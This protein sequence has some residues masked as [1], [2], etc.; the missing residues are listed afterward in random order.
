MD[1]LVHDV[2]YKNYL[3][4]FSSQMKTIALRRVEIAYEQCECDAIFFLSCTPYG[5]SCEK[6][7]HRVAIRDQKHLQAIVINYVRNITNC[8]KYFLQTAMHNLT[9]LS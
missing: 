1:G 4:S 6:K 8:L 3:G 9:I 5:M 2:S 7:G